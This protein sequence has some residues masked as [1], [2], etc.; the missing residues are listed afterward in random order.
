MLPR[1]KLPALQSVLYGI[2]DGLGCVPQ[3]HGALADHVI[4]I[5]VPIHVVQV[6]TPSVLEK[7]GR[8]CPGGGRCCSR[9]PPAIDAIAPTGISNG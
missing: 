9:R 6:G 8:L 3:K 5:A 4:Q 7:Q 2:H 1:E